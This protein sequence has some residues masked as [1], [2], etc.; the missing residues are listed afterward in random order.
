MF[1]IIKISLEK[2]I[3]LIITSLITINC[4]IFC[5]ILKIKFIYLCIF[6]IGTFAISYKI[7]YKI[8]RDYIQNKIKLIY[9]LIYTTKSSPLEVLYQKL[10]LP[11]KS[12]EDAQKEVEE[13]A[14]N[15]NQDIIKLEFNTAFRKEFLQNLSHEFKTP[16]FAIQSYVET[17]LDG[18]YTDQIIC[19]NFLEKTFN[20]IKRISKLMEDLDT[21]TQLELNQT[22]LNK[23]SFELIKLIKE[24]FDDCTILLEEKNITYS[25]INNAGNEINVLA[26]KDKIYQV[27]RNILENAIKYGKINGRIKIGLNIIENRKLYIEITDNGIGIEE[28]HLPRIF[29][30]FY[31]T[32]EAR[33]RDVGGSGLGLAICKHIVESHNEIINIRSKLNVG[34]TIG[35]TLSII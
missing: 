34:T 8:F 24:V 12:I 30:R 26:E 15:F 10:I 14:K 25:I 31:R 20:N 35:F 3:V 27:I 9:K 28:S 22:I 33:S 2:K 21:I 29:E 5:A 6:G 7:I 32:D 19:K 16:I 18:A 13:W 23:Q 4:L 11:N 1:K 17:L